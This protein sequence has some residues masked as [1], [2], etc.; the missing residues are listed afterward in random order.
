MEH[1][2][3]I[4]PQLWGITLTVLAALVALIVYTG[5]RLQD[6]VDMIPGLVTDRVKTVHDEIV[7]KIDTMNDTQKGLER[8]VRTNLTSLDR[9]MIAIE[10]RCDMTHFQQVPGSPINGNRHS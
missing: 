10:V 6:N 3:E 5:K 9:R 2:Q 8:D 1:A 7:K 4:L